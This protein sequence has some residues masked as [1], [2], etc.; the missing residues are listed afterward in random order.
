[1]S[2]SRRLY[3]DLVNKDLQSEFVE[4]LMKEYPIMFKQLTNQ[5]IAHKE[6]D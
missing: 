4:W 1:M 2:V 6:R 5:F 3:W